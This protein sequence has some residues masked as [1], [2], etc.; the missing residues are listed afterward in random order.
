VGKPEGKGSLGRSRH[1]WEA[2]EWTTLK[3]YDERIWTGCLWLGVETVV[4]V[5]INFLVPHTVGN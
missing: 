3:K 4:N 2:P 5:V 1:R